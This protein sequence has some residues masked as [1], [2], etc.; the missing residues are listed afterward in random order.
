MLREIPLQVQLQWVGNLGLPSRT[1]DTL[2]AARV[3]GEHMGSC[4]SS[5]LQPQA[6]LTVMMSPAFTL[7]LV[8]S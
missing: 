2:V 7:R 4:L 6:G 5:L 8:R 3:W 1:P